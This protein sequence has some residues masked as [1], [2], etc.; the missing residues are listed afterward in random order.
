MAQMQALDPEAQ[1]APKNLRQP[2]IGAAVG[3]KPHGAS[4]PM[5]RSSKSPSAGLFE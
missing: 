1:V 3:N 2:G 5:T 4:L